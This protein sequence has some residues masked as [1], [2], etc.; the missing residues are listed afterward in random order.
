MGMP[1]DLD[2]DLALLSTD[3]GDIWTAQK[4]LEFQ[5]NEFL[6]SA[7][8]WETAANILVDLKTTV[9]HIQWHIKNIRRPVNRIVRFAYRRA[10]D[11]DD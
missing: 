10:M 11:S 2:D 6:Q 1:D 9:D 8:D 4:M 7:H 5:L 3:L